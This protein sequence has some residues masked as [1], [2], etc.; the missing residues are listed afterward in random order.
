MKGMD[1]V[2]QGR[3]EDCTG[4]NLCYESARQKTG[5]DP[6][7]AI[8]MQPRL[9]HLAGEKWQFLPATAGH[10]RILRLERIDIRTSQLITPLFEF[11]GA[12]AGLR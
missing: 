5:I 9:A 7:R 10:S 12:C 6:S 1:Y 3:P 2:L 4:C 11:S 8:N